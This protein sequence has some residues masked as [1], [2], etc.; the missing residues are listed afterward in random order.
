[1]KNSIAK[2]HFII[3]SRMGALLSFI[4]CLYISN[5]NVFRVPV[6]EDG[7]AFAILS[8]KKSTSRGGML[9]NMSYCSQFKLL[10]TVEMK[11]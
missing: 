2:A 11:R 8:H 5:I 9:I 1:M 7:P 3:S 4:F 6:H 10:P